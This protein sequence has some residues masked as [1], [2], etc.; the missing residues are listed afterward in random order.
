[1]QLIEPWHLVDGSNGGG[2]RFG[3]VS[4][5]AKLHHREEYFNGVLSFALL[6]ALLN[7]LLAGLLA[8]LL[9]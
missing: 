5:K 3:G 6:N 7:A 2:Q 9:G 1:M 8:G 4:T